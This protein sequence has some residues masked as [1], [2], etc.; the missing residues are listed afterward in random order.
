MVPIRNTHTPAA[1]H[2][3]LNSPFTWIERTRYQ[4]LQDIQPITV[5]AYIET[6][7]RHGRTSGTE[8]NIKTR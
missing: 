7:Q 1:Y 2:Q 3:R 4:D 6:L 5:A 8:V